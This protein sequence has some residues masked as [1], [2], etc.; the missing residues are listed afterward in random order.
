MPSSNNRTI[1]DLCQQNWKPAVC[2]TQVE[3]IAAAT[4]FKV[5]IFFIS[6]STEEMK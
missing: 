4:V 2:A 1:K 6:P 3:V 5:P